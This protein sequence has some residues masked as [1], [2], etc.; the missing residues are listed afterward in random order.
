MDPYKQASLKTADNLRTIAQSVMIQ[1]LSQLSL[2]EIEGLVDAVARVAPAG[3]VPGVILN[4]LA[5]LSG[6]RPP[7][8]IVK[9]DV[10]LLFRGVESALDKAVY[11]AFFAGPAAVIWGYQNLLQLAGKDPN[12]SFPEGL[13]QFYVEYALREDTARHAN[14]THGFDTL[15]NTHNFALSQAD[16]LTAWVMATVSILH[17][18][19]ALLANEWRERV[20]IALL[21]EVTAQQPDAEHYANLYRQWEKQR[22]F[23]RGHDA[24]PQHDYATYRRIQFDQFL[25]DNTRN[26]SMETYQ[27]WVQRIQALKPER[28]AYKQQMSILAYLEPGAYGE[29]RHHFP[30]SDAKVGLIYQG[31]YYLLPVCGQNGRSPILVEEV[32]QQIAGILSLPTG[33]TSVKLAQLAS[34]KRAAFSEFRQSMNPTLAQSLE[35]LCYA[36]I[37]INADQRPHS[38]PLSD[39][40]QAERGVGDHALTIFDTGKTFVFDQSHIFFDGAWGAALAEIITREATSWAVYLHQQAA[41]TVPAQII[42]PLALPIGSTEQRLIQKAD[43]TT[44]EVNV[45]NTQVSLSH[46]L[47]TRKLFKQRN[48]LLQL[49]VNDLFILYRAV[50]ALTYQPPADLLTELQQLAGKKHAKTAV[51]L[52]HK[53]LTQPPN[54]NPAIFI[55]IDGSRQVPRERL[56]PLVFEAPLTE[57]D[58]I[59]LHNRT[60]AALANYQQGSQEEWGGAYAEFD[61]L[62]RTYLASLAGFGQVLSR[63]KELGIKG[64]S[65]SSGSIRMLANMPKPIQ[66]LLD[67]VP[68]RFDLL[69]DLIKGREIFSNVGAVVAGSTLTRFITAKDDNDKKELAWGVLTDANGVVTLTL[70]DFR[71][72]VGALT[73]AGYRPL[74]QQIAQHYLD[75]YAN[76]FN[77][78]LR[79]IRRITL[80]S[81][82]TRLDSGA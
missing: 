62:Q 8:N 71:P 58:L 34:M 41:P 75:S 72:Y 19:P 56:F 15:L 52:A 37:I 7:A 2:P 36:P 46:I 44:L 11:G 77:Q 20:Y 33:A 30:F 51:A 82:E 14:E 21:A 40:R 80:S 1:G 48:D 9:R 5:R 42:K 10:N 57:L 29:T 27:V 28:D 23:G 64:E 45:E 73:E 63:A 65:A 53:T 16:R 50:H 25:A 79:Q 4:G 43:R 31:R 78:Y 17:Q 67:T 39:I 18:F 69:N 59:S 49:T 81:R 32:R 22:P 60:L 24:D 66:R 3:N 38:L 68:N 47:A 76:G 12:D 6:R 35:Q 74:A 61:Q 54:A 70:R 55:P 13:W 26:L